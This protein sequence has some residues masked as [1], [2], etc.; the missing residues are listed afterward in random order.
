MESQPFRDFSAP[1]RAIPCVFVLLYSS[2]NST[3]N[4]VIVESQIPGGIE[5][6]RLTVPIRQ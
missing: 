4:S 5:Q 2:R 1:N 3:L 6:W